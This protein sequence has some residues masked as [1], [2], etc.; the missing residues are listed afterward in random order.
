MTE[1]DPSTQS[2][3][4]TDDDPGLP[5]PT[6]REVSLG[7]PFRW[8]ARG[9][10]DLRAAPG[11]SLFYGLCF[12]AMGVLTV[13]MFLHA[14]EYIAALASGFLLVGPRPGLGGGVLLRHVDLL[15]VLQ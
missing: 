3:P 4:R 10:A 8:I 14:Y 5:F 15:W 1:Q 11:P 7:A 12:A 9:A 6:V 2:R 13:V